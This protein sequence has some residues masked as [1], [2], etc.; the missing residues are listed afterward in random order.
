MGW[1]RLISQ[2]ANGPCP[3]LRA[4]IWCFAILVTTTG[5]WDPSCTIR[6]GACAALRACLNVME[7]RETRFRIQYLHNLFM[8]AQKGLVLQTQDDSSSYLSQN[9]SLN[10]MNS[11]ARRISGGSPTQPHRPSPSNVSRYLQVSFKVWHQADQRRILYT[12]STFR[13]GGINSC[14]SPCD[15]RAIP[16]HWSLHAWP[17]QRC[18]SKSTCISES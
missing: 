9:M 6:L 16:L 12:P 14:V 2:L 13:L 11:M 18:H 1:L 5:L 3:L 4:N 8:E 15:R 17:L 10:R 7:K